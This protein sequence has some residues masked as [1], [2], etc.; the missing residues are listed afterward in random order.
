MSVFTYET[1]EVANASAYKTI[2]LEPSH[3]FLTQ[4]HCELANAAFSWSMYGER[5]N[6]VANS[7]FVPVSFAFEKCP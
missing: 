7:E 3:K 1:L 5:D 4:S 6:S 2:A